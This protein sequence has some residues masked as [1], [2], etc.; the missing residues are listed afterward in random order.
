MSRAWRDTWKHLRVPWQLSLSPIFLWGHFL[1][2]PDV[3]AEFWIGFVAAHFFLYTGITAYNSSYD[4]DVGPVGGMLRPPP[5]PNGLRPL[6]LAMLLLGGVLAAS[7]SLAF[8][9]TYGVIAVMGI[10]YSHPL[11]RWKARPI[12]SAATVFVGQ[13][14]LGFLM[15]WLASGAA[16]QAALSERGVLGSLSAA[17]T[18]LGLYPVTQVFQVEEDAG[19]GDRTLAVS[20]GPSRALRFGMACLVV[21]GVCA[22]ALMLL[23]YS[24][25]DAVLLV[26]AYIATLACVG[27]FAADYAR[28][29]HG[30]VSG[31]RTAMRLNFVSAGGFLIF[32]A[33]HLLRVL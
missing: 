13:G 33:L 6:S 1:A 31:F 23:Q 19:R 7:L 15:G 12:P 20:L 9:L 25:L 18:T 10:A 32:V 26:V 5:V 3:S 24:A 14:L 17:F 21:A 22:V 16:P 2:S 29:R 28:D 8:V 30:V 11:T 27:R 4:R